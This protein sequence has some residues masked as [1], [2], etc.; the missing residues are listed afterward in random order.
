MTMFFLLWIKSSDEQ[1]RLGSH[2]GN[3]AHFSSVGPKC[4][5]VH[6]GASQ[7]NNNKNGQLQKTASKD[8]FPAFDWIKKFTF[9]PEPP[10]SYSKKLTKS[11][12]KN[13]SYI[14]MPN[15]CQIFT[16][17]PNKSFKCRSRE[18]HFQCFVRASFTSHFPLP[19]LALFVSAARWN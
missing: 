3:L 10:K 7:T 5:H 19:E 13:Q 15:S 16:P 17:M 14:Y 2:K 8:L 9:L 4:P 11:W 6:R 1:R 18:F 12:K